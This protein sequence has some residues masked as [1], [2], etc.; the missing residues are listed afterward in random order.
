MSIDRSHLES[1]LRTLATAD[2]DNDLIRTLVTISHACLDLFHVD[3]CGIMI[4]DD[5]NNLRDIVASDPTGH[6]LE[7]AEMSTQQGPCTD[8][9]ITNSLVAATDCPR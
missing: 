2:P 3:G 8:S 6:L 9:Y 7:H 4:V 5:N 1:S